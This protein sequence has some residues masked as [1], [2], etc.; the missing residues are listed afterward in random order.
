MEFVTEAVLIMFLI[1]LAIIFIPL[2]IGMGVAILIAA[3]G[4]QYFGVVFLTALAIWIVFFAV[5]FLYC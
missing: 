3:T 2:L 1:V 5:W 4:L